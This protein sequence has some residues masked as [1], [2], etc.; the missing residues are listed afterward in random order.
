MLSPTGYLSRTLYI[1]YWFSTHFALALNPS[2]ESWDHHCAVS[3]PFLL[4]FLPRMNK[5]DDKL[6]IYKKESLKK[7]SRI[8]KSNKFTFLGLVKR[9]QPFSMEAVQHCCTRHV[10]QIWPRCCTIQRL[11]WSCSRVGGRGGGKHM[12]HLVPN[13]VAMGYVEIGGVRLARPLVCNQTAARRLV[14]MYSR[15]DLSKY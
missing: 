11:A 1:Q 2:N 6:S 10:V 5:F 8:R 15:V 4:N 13:N 14:G 3:S 7:R 9:T 12:Q